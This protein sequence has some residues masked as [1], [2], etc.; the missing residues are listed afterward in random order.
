[1]LEELFKKSSSG[2]RNLKNTKNFSVDVHEYSNGEEIDIIKIPINQNHG[3]YRRGMSSD[4]MEADNPE[5]LNLL[6]Y[7]FNR[8]LR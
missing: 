3:K 4:Q 2:I 5:N 7:D 1:M 8:K 6:F